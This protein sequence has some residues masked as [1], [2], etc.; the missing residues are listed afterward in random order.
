MKIP[1]RQTESFI[2][3]P[4]PSVRVILVYGPDYGLMRERTA[5][6]GKTVVEDLN[7]PFNVAALNGDQLTEDPA[8]L[9]D[10]AGAISM[11]G[12]DRLIRIENAGDKLTPLLKDYLKDPS[13]LALI[14]LEAGELGPR[15]PL[16]QLCE[17]ADNAAAIACYV[18]NERD[19][20][21]LI[22][23]MLQEHGLTIQPDAINWL[24]SSLVGDH[25]RA[26]NEVEKLITYMGGAQNAVTLEDAQACCGEAGAQSLD[27]LIHAVG[28]AR[29]EAALKSFAVLMEE[30]VPFMAALRALQNHFRRLHVTKSRMAT[31]EPADLAMKSLSPPV[32]FKWEQS[33]KGQL[34][35][36]SLTR[37][38]N[39]LTRLNALEAQCKQTGAPVETLC[40]QAILALSVR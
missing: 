34:N 26:R 35:S 13:P 15:S 14:V 3:S 10:E 21:G 37:L 5:L 12:G 32:F 18:E 16:R 9:S 24:A 1:P 40:S 19:L 20:S 33:F 30:G 38:E 31:G 11:M 4:D 39:A 6:I 7:D 2:K 22:R 23:S 28:G 36:W 29:S 25:Q 27:D 17:K 8:R